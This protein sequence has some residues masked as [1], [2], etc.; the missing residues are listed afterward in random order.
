MFWQ[1]VLFL[2]LHTLPLAAVFA[3]TPALLARLGQS[4]EII[5]LL[6][7]YLLALLPGVWVDAVY[8]WVVGTL[9]QMR[10]AGGS[11]GRG[12]GVNCIILCLVA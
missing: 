4:P 12:S 3:S 5:R 1:A 9:I 7:P 8:R 11:L 6:R 10:G 2:M